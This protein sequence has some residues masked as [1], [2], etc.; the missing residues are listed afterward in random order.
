MIVKC[1]V[2]ITFFQVHAHIKF[3][4]KGI[5]GLV[6]D[7]VSTNFYYP[8]FAAINTSNPKGRY[9]VVPI[10]TSNPKGRYNVVP[11]N[12]KGRYNVVPINVCTYKSKKFG[13]EQN[14]IINA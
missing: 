12:P 9:N 5:G 4:R 7:D 11:I 3:V 14:F 6:Y 13:H 8:H 2:S 10:N 1:H